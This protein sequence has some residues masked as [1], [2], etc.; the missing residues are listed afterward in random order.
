[1]QTT[2]AGQDLADLTARAQAGDAAAFS[3]L[4]ARHERLIY[5]Y[6][7][8]M[9]ADPDDAADIAQ[10][11]FIKAWAA[12]GATRGDLNLS[13]WLHRIA[14]NACLDVLRRRQRWRM[15]PWEPPA[16]DHLLLAAPAD[17][18][19]RATLR[20]SDRDEAA[21][22]VTA[23]LTALRPRHRSALV[24]REF[25]GL[26]CEEIGAVMG[27]TRSAVKSMLFRAREEFRAVYARLD[28]PRSAVAS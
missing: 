7:Y 24:M 3:A 5:S 16:H 11:T 8:R 19:E 13:A 26:S 1:M 12:I 9:L 10:A 22:Q 18:P 27:L 25:E 15:L 21:R 20:Q 23:V 2:L 6:C 17:E 4:M 28:A 14:Y